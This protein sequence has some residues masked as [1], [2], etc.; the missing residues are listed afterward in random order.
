MSPNDL[1]YYGTRAQTERTLAAQAASEISADIHLTLA[2]F[3]E[4]L[5]ELEQAEAPLLCIV[6][7]ADAEF[8]ASG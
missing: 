7:E 4:R 5:V 3:Y 6:S 8:M 2:A 1:Q